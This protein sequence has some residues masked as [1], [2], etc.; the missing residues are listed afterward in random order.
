VLPNRATAAAVAARIPATRVLICTCGSLIWDGLRT[1]E[2]N[3][4]K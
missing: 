4:V 2:F 3:H 1:T